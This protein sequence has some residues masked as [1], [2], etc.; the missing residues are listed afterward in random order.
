MSKYDDIRHLSRPVYEDLP[1]MPLA[2]RA[3]Q[4]SPFAAVV[5]YDKAVAEAARLTDPRIERMEDELEKIDQEMAVL[6]KRI[7]EMPQVRIRYFV[8]DHRKS[9]GSY[10]EKQGRVRVIDTVGNTLVFADGEV[11]AIREIYELTFM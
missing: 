2:D 1:P 3:A 9:G 7:K 5:G 8:P 4:F 6:S 10:R 11:I